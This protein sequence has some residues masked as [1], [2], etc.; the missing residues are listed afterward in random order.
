MAKLTD[1]QKRFVD[2][3]LVDLNAT[4]AAVRAGY[5]EKTAS[6]IGS[7]NLR[8]PEIAARIKRRQDA[9]VKRTEITQDFVLLE[10]FK[11]AKA[12][13]SM[14]M[15][16]NGRGTAKL[17]PTEELAPEERAAISGIKKG[18]F[19]TEIKTYDKV[20][21]LE[22]LGRHVGLFGSDSGGDNGN[23]DDGFVDALKGAAKGA[24]QDEDKGD[25]P[26]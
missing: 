2:E 11:I 19:G 4:Q 21:A 15:T 7:E 26:V 17:T 8:K 20:K 18:K 16:I 14:F 5:S 6:S 10:L 3:Y 23:T 9:Q 22:L 13:G 24:W 12:N 1:L 25:V